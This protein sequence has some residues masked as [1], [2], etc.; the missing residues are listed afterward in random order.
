[1]RANKLKLALVT[2]LHAKDHKT[3]IIHMSLTYI[4]YHL[5]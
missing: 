2:Y 4:F 5:C 1:M 3:H